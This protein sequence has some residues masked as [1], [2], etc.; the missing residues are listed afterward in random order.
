M[1]ETDVLEVIN[2]IIVSAR[3]MGRCGLIAIHG[4]TNCFS[5][6]AV[7]EKGIRF[8]GNGQAPVHKY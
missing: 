1:L 3:K 4:F 8:I 7:M 5:I 2:E 6:G